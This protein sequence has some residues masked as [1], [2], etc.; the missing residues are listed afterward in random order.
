MN[1]KQ[2]T[3]M[4]LELKSIKEKLLKM[5]EK[6]TRSVS[7]I[8]I[9]GRVF[10]V[11]Q[12]GAEKRM[13]LN[14]TIKNRSEHLEEEGLEFWTLMYLDSYQYKAG[15]TVADL[16]DVPIEEIMKYISTRDYEAIV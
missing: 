15:D 1:Q 2:I 6:I 9:H 11:S 8:F 12:N 7:D 3:K 10:V 13:L 5:E 16:K 4:F 14:T